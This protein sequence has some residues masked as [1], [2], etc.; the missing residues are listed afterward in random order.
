MRPRAVQRWERLRPPGEARQPREAK[1]EEEAVDE[2]SKALGDIESKGSNDKPDS[3]V[4]DNPGTKGAEASDDKADNKDKEGDRADSQAPNMDQDSEK[5]IW[6]F[7]HRC[8]LRLPVLH[9]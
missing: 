3:G 4:E 5:L 2:K 6:R 7:L 1:E 8:S 9:W